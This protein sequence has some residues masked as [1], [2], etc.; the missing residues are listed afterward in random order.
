MYRS[1]MPI[2]ELHDFTRRHRNP[3]IFLPADRSTRAANHRYSQGKISSC[4]KADGFTM[5]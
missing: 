4:S 3:E 1:L 5:G 2:G